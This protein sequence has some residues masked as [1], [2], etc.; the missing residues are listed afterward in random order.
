MIPKQK[1]A[2]LL[3]IEDALQEITGMWIEMSRKL[4]EECKRVSNPS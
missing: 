3:H 1:I 4:T 2:L